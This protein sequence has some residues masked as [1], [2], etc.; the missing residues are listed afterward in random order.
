MYFIFVSGYSRGVSVLFR[1]DKIGRWSDIL[2]Q[3]VRAEWPEPRQPVRA[4]GLP[5]GATGASS[6]CTTNV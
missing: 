3:C 2:F 4:A 6:C 5:R 1:L